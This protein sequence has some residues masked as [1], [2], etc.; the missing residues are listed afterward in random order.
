MD[1]GHPRPEYYMLL[2]DLWLSIVPGGRGQ[3]CLTCVGD[4]LG[5]SVTDDDF[6]F[7]PPEMLARL[8]APPSILN[9]WQWNDRLMPSEQ[10]FRNRFV[11][12]V[13]EGG[14]WE[15]V[16][17]KHKAD[18]GLFNELA[19]GTKDLD[20]FYDRL[21]Q[22]SGSEI[23]SIAEWRAAFS[24]YLDEAHA[25]QCLRAAEAAARRSNWQQLDLFE[26]AA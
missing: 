2:D 12:P 20:E 14:A 11:P 8:H 23:R 6:I 15:A 7:T 17:G 5:R 24:R 10:A 9:D 13:I 16:L 26:E 4:R 22:R 3:L 25:E 1:C 18:H 19:F 21:L